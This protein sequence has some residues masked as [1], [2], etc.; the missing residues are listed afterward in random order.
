MRN[1]VTGSCFPVCASRGGG[2]VKHKEQYAKG[3]GRVGLG[4]GMQPRAVP[5]QR[6]EG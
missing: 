2:H 4:S 3:M 6:R 1:Q 5:A